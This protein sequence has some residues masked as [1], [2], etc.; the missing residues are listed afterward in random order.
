MKLNEE[1]KRSLLGLVG[2][3]LKDRLDI[4]KDVAGPHFNGCFQ[5][6][7]ESLE[8][9]KTQRLIFFERTKSGRAIRDYGLTCQGYDLWTSMSGKG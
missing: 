9:L 4:Q 7:I 5:D 1:T 6:A 3:C 2:C 8:L